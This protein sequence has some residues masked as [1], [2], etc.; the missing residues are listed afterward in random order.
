MATPRI[1]S[2]EN[3]DKPART[4]GL[5]SAHYR[6]FLRQCDPSLKKKG[7]RPKAPFR[8]CSI[9]EC[10][11]KVRA[12]GLCGKHYG[13]LWRNGSTKLSR[14]EEG[15]GLS[16]ISKNSAY[17]GDDCLTWPFGRKSK[18]GGY[19]IVYFQ[20]RARHAS[21]VMCIFAHGEPPTPSHEAAHSCGMGH[22]G[23]VN[24]RH[25]RWAS[26]LENSRDK[27]KHGTYVRGEK[28]NGAKL[29]A[30]DVRKIRSLAGDVPT[31]EIAEMFNLHRCY[32]DQ[33]IRRARWGWLD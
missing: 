25:L 3:C 16:W 15:A 27:R 4:R 6:K 8:P 26:P 14:A 7:G 19:G 29:S 23:C 2:A 20:G 33:I 28:V 30:D 5:C 17:S 11:R 18:N 31:A 24:P 10:G 9:E 13:R 32:V 21:R 1:C 22:E 12:K